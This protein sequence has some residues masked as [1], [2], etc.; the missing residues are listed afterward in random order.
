MLISS[1]RFVIFTFIIMQYITNVFRIRLVI[2]SEKLPVH[3]S[4]F[5]GRTDGRTDDVINN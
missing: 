1:L 5:I 4:R 2:E 3:G